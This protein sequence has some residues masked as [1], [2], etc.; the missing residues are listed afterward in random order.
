MI[1]DDARKSFKS[2]QCSASVTVVNDGQCLSPKSQWCFFGVQG[3]AIARQPTRTCECLGT[4]VCMHPQA[5]S[6]HSG[7]YTGTA[8]SA[9]T[10]VLN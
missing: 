6:V 2:K 1:L 10:L 8:Q 4:P 3:P 5:K 7:F 9:G